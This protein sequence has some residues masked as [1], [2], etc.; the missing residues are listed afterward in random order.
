MPIAPTQ[1]SPMD[2]FYRRIDFEQLKVPI[3]FIR[4]IEAIFCLIVFASF[5]GWQFDLQII[6]DSSLKTNQT[7]KTSYEFYS[8]D[9]R[10][11]KVHRC[12]DSKTD[13]LPFKDDYGSGTEFYSYLIP[14]SLFFTTG[15]LLF[16]LF[17]YGVYASDD[18]L[19]IL[20]LTVTALLAVF[21]MFGTL[22]FS[23]SARRIE[24]ATK[25]ENVNSTLTTLD[26]CGGMK[27]VVSS[28]S[29]YATLAIASLAGVGLF[30]LF[31]GNIWYIYKETPY[32]RNRQSRRN[33][34]HNNLPATEPYTLE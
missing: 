9:I 16:Y 24:E 3:G 22:F 5:H 27:C 12:N 25:P 32:F 34:H 23:I 26:I 17:S 10:N 21:W 13:V 15:M 19:P 8:I 4:L 2:R 11:Y 33:L 31:T 18:R 6:C 1:S 14:L 28:Y 30:I 7:I 20:D 29:V